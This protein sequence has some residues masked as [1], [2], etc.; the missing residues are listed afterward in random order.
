MER[1]VLLY[2]P[3]NHLTAGSPRSLGEDVAVSVF[4]CFCDCRG[5]AG[6]CQLLVGRNDADGDLGI[7][8]GD[9]ARFL[10]TGGVL[11]FV[12]LDAERGELVA[13]HLADHVIVLADAC[14]EGDHVYA[15]HLSGVVADVA[16]DAVYVDV[17]SQLGV[18]VDGEPHG[19]RR[20][21]SCPSCRNAC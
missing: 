3:V 10:G 6:D 15:A 1:M 13:H 4:A 20:S 12:Q 14:G 16:D 2:G 8:G 9:D 11:L 7:R 19:G 21:R 5:L 17:E 18:L